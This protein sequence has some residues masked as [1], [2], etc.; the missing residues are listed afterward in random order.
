MNRTESWS[1]SS[2]LIEGNGDEEVE[3][4]QQRH[5]RLYGDTMVT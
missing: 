2:G 4:V 1:K 3:R 5:L